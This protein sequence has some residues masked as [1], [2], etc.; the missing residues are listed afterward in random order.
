[1]L[2]V[3]LSTKGGGIAGVES[4]NTE[5]RYQAMKV[6]GPDDK[7]IIDCRNRKR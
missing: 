4:A 3:A 6:A 5:I 7:P 2:S 1:M